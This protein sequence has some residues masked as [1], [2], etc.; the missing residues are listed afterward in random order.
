MSLSTQAPKLK[1]LISGAGIAGPCLAYWLSKTR[2]NTSITVVERSPVPRATGQAVDIRGT[3]ISVIEKMKLKDAVQARSTTEEGTRIVGASG[4]T[5]AEFGKGDSFTAEYEILRADLCE[6]FLDETHKLP[7]VRYVYGDFVTSLSQSESSADVK[8]NS[9]SEESY[10]LVVAADGSTSKIR[11][12]I[13][14]EQTR[15]DSYK[16]IG[17]YIAYFSIPM[18]SSDTKHWYWYNEPKGL[19]VMTR[20]H[21][22]N[23]TVGAYLCI[24]LPAHGQRD[25]AIEDALSQGA[26]AQKRVLREYFSKAGWQTKRVLEGMNTSSDFYMSRTARVVLPRWHNNRTVLLGDAAFA[27]FGIGTSLAIQSA[28]SLAGELSKIKGGED[29]PTALDKYEESFRKVQGVN[30]DLPLGFPQIAFPQTSWGIRARDAAAWVVG[31]TKAY[32]LLPGEDRVR[33]DKLPE[34]EWV[35]V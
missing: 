13:L 9:G 22:N 1:V 2:L 11:S 6:L 32:K 4:K 14:D 3:A 31:K 17:Q 16:P 27:T 30:E 10:D 34:Y 33:K 21:R 12:M 19:G 5:V 25:S 26:K 28:Y 20:P 18:N 8:F 29:V 7:N 35:G 15:K 23:T 24:T